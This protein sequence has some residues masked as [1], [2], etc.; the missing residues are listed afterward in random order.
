[1]STNSSLIKTVLH[2]ALAEGVYRDIVT[3]NSSYYYFL[4]KTLNWNIDDIPPYPIDSYEYERDTRSEIITM[5]QIKPSDVSFVIPRIDWVQ[6]T[7]YDMFDD[8]YS[9]QIIGINIVDGGSGYTSIPT[10]TITGGGGTG[11]AFTAVVDIQLGKIV[12]VDLVSRG[13][14]YTSVPTVTVTGGNGSGANLQAVLNKA[15]SGTQILEDALFYVMTDE[16]NVYKCL[17]NNN[18]SPSN[19]KPTGTQVEPIKTLDGYIWKYMYNVPIAL[20]NKFLTNQHIPVVSAL[21][22]Q[23]YSNGSLDTVL[24]NNK[25]SGYASANIIVE[26]DGYLEAD[27]T[28]IEG[29]VIADGGSGYVTAT[30]VISDPVSDASL[31]AAGAGVFQGQKIYNSSKDFYEV[32]SAGTLGLSEPSHRLGTYKNGSASVKYIGTTATGTATLTS[33]SVTAITLNGGIREVEIIN[34]G[35]GYTSPPAISFVGGGGSGATAVAKMYNGSVGYVIITNFGSGYTSAPDVVFGTQW[36]SGATVT[37]NDQI[38]YGTHLYT[39]SAVS[40]GGNTNTLGT[41]GPTHD[42]LNQVVTNGNVSLKYVGEVASGQANRRFGAGYQQAPSIQISGGVEPAVVAFQTSKSRAKLIP[43]IENNQITGVITE[44]AGVGYTVANIEVTSSSGTGAQLLA[45]LSVGNIETLQANNELLTTSG[46]IDA[47]KMISGGYGY[48]AAYVAITGDGTGATATAIVEP[49]TGAITKI[50][51]TNRGSGYTF[52][53]V[54]IYGNGQ[55][56]TARA[57]ISP[58]GGHGKNAPE[59]FFSRTLMFYS[60]VSTDLNQGLVVNNDYRQIGIVKNPKSYQSVSKYDELVGST[61][62]IVE[63]ANLPIDENPASGF[64]RDMDLYA[65]RGTQWSASVALTVNSQVYYQSNLYLV[66]Q[67]GTTSTVAPSHSSGSAQ[68]GTA[69]LQYVGSPRRRYRIVSL[70]SSS[71]LLQSLDNDVPVVN[72]A[73]FNYSN[74]NFIPLSVGS[75]DVDKY[76]GQLL[77]IDNK[78]GFTPSEDETVILRTVIKF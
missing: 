5:K 40:G 57:I 31:F 43:I 62:F 74:R 26:G 71:V 50:N 7:V 72:E 27:P 41:T 47:I 77:Y 65:L 21:T 29:T 19:Y 36:V 78:N 15:P 68:N 46:T 51:I 49:S 30:V 34:A 20:R 28:L 76:S 73:I 17:D 54:V 44:N 39:V 23:F 8:L 61:C 10:V 25:G 64:F 37:L 12:G 66:T 35:S 45:N 42:T 69:V 33:G 6:G 3:K 14:G 18:N 63:V 56:A 22:N 59:E 60:N 67:A 2:R 16:Y 32:V 70:T 48:G 1:M 58:Y 53:N 75:P 52:A 55:A 38:W 9:T 4:G 24:I 11:A 13:T